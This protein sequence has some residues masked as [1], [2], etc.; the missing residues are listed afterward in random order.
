M[1]IFL[2]GVLMAAAG[3]VFAPPA[4]VSLALAGLVLVYAVALW[5]IFSAAPAR[6][7]GKMI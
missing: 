2:F 5:A 4:L 6:A 3:S 7:G 1:K